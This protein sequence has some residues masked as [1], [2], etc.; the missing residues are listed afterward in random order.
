MIKA[1]N[2]FRVLF[3][4]TFIDTRKVVNI[5]ESKLPL[6]M[7]WCQLVLPGFEEIMGVA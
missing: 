7:A 5:Q 3:I 6:G 4:E 2:N 1:Y